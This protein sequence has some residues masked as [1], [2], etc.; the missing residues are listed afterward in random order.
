MELETNLTLIQQQNNELQLTD[1]LKDEFLATTS[2]EL[3]TPLHGMLG[4][5]ETL[6]CG[7]YGELTNEQQN[8]LQVINNS[9]QRLAQLIDDLLDY[10]KMRYGNLHINKSAVDL[11]SAVHLVLALSKHLLGSKP[12]RIINQV[13]DNIAQV[14]ADEQRLEQVLYNL[15]G[16]AIEYTDE[17]KVIINAI[18]NDNN[19]Q[20][21]VI[22][23]GNGIDSTQLE[24][25]FEPLSQANIDSPY[26]RQGAGLG[27]SISRQL[28]ELMDGKLSVTSQ[29]HIGTTFS[30][31][32]PI[33]TPTN[34]SDQEVSTHQHFQAPTPYQA[35]TITSNSLPA[36]PGAP[37][38]I[39]ADDEAVNLQVLMSFLRLGGYRVKTAMSGQETLSLIQKEQPALILLDV[40]MPGM[41]GYE[42]CQIVRQKYDSKELPIIMLTAL[43]QSK[44]RVRGFE[45]GAND[46]VSKPFNQKEITAR[47]T[48][49]L[50]SMQTRTLNNQKCQL[51]KA[52]N[53]HQ[54]VETSLLETQEQLLTLLE[55][56]PD[57]ILCIRSDEKIHFASHSAGK[58]FKRSPQQLQHFT[59]QDI[60]V[61]RSLKQQ[62]TPITEL[63]IYIEEKLSTIAASVITLPKISGLQYLII[64]Y[65]E[66]SYDVDRI[67]NLEKAVNALSSYAFD[68]NSEQLQAL[69][70]LG[71]EFTRLV[72]KAEGKG[73]DKTRLKREL[74]VDVMTQV[75][76]YWE[77]ESGKTKFD[78]AEQSQLWKVYLDR[79]TLQT[80]TLDK[81]LH[82]ETLPKTPRWRTVLSTID[83][84]LANC[85]SETKQ[86]DRIEKLRL[87][88]QKLLA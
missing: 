40:M 50:Q 16:N 17:G 47:I 84:V 29:P 26:Y 46:Y 20:V 30:F 41:S 57:A 39:I 48:A 8:Q 43:N 78:L 12:L 88:L 5:T 80:R 53:E 87:Q 65:T 13:P 35:I 83:Y 7:A 45:A 77:K 10:H 60:I 54:Q 2:H 55:H 67:S 22:D 42:V 75:M 71:G 3:R 1:K 44:D 37:L 28:I 81:Y 31:S 82:I 32:L 62:D 70:E 63:D 15:I 86:R 19:V 23:T 18:L 66:N 9:G 79:S 21:Q 24:Q 49:H 51:E 36:N 64:L 4:I 34:K 52:I 33:A 58:L 14:I 74:L 61:K 56:S 69:K 11:S 85:D 38:I 59:L 72:D 6:K 25:I 68:G 76:S 27:L 73:S